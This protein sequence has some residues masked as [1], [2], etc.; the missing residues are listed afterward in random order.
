MSA[1]HL[2]GKAVALAV[3]EPEVAHL[4][5]L[6][7]HPRLSH[8]L[9]GL[10]IAILAGVGDDLRD[11][12]DVRAAV[13]LVLVGG[14]V[15]GI[16]REHLTEAGDT[17]QGARQYSSINSTTSSPSVVPVLV[18]MEP[19]TAGFRLRVTSA[20]SRSATRSRYIHD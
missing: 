12:A 5:V 1:A 17:Y 7:I 4:A 19:E 15:V 11:G 10:A 2:P 3:V 6:D 14:V 8:L 9:L 13:G 16:P 18:E 20:R